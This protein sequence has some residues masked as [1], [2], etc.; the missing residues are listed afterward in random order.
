[1][2]QTICYCFGF[3]DNE[4]KEDVIKNNG[5]SRIEQFIVNKKKEGKCACHLNNPRGT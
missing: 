4:I 2:N 1:M 3:T 5:I